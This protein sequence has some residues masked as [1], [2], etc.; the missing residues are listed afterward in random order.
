MAK[1]WIRNY[2]ASRNQKI[3][4]TSIAV[5]GQVVKFLDD[6]AKT[7]GVIVLPPGGYVVK[8]DAFLA[9]EK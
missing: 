1:Y 6:A 9:D 3:E 7:V 2:G 5:D 4:A 8:E